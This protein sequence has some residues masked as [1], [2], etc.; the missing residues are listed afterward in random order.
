MELIIDFDKINDPEKR[1]WLLHTLKLMGIGFHSADAPQTVDKYNRDLE[2][3]DDEV[4]RGDFIT[5]EALKAE[6]LKR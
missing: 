4:E 3:G 5:A 6:A 1:E 2:M